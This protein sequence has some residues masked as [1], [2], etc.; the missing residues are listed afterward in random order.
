MQLHQLRAQLTA[1]LIIAVIKQA[2]L[3]VDFATAAYAPFGLLTAA[4]YQQTAFKN[5]SKT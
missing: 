1:W 3:M 4:P 5:L 2:H